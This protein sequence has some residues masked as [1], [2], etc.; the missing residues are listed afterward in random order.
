MT[1]YK[2]FA[3]MLQNMKNFP[4]PTKGHFLTNTADLSKGES[5]TQEKY[6]SQIPY[7][8]YLFPLPIARSPPP[9]H[10]RTIAASSPG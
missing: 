7:P 5:K 10:P 6:I 9:T 2:R 1:S 4:A 8:S 3:M